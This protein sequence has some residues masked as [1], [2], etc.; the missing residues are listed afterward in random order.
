M[1]R[2]PFNGNFSM[3]RDFGVYDPAYSNY[4]GSRHPGTDYGLPAGTQLVAPMSGTVTVFNRDAGLKTG[5]GK[6]VVVTNG[7]VQMKMCHMNRIDVVNGQQVSEGQGI[8]ISG[9]TGYVVDSQGR[10]GTPG[11]AHLHLEMLIDGNYVRVQDNLSQGGNVAELTPGQ[12]DK[13]IKMAKLEEPTATELN[14][15]N[16]KRD[17]GLGIDTLWNAYGKINYAK[18]QQPFITKGDVDNLLRDVGLTPTQAD[19]D[20]VK[21]GPKEFAYYLQ[22]RLKKHLQT[23]AGVTRESAL[24]YVQDNLN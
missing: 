19:Y 24:K 9:Y 14:D 13:L 18:A 2:F 23:S 10:I 5:R 4:P 6:E 15:T 12:Q 11:G 21:A 17:P 3:T 8:G 7:R 1:A 16:W 20:A 22:A